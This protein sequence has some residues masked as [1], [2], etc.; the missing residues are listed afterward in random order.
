[1]DK[2]NKVHVTINDHAEEH[3]Y[4]PGGYG[5]T[6]AAAS[7]KTYDGSKDADGLAERAK[8]LGANLRAQGIVRSNSLSPVRRR[9][10]STFRKLHSQTPGQLYLR[11]LSL[12]DYCEEEDD[13][14]SVA[15]EGEH[16]PLRRA[17]SF[18]GTDL[19]APQVA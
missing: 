5:S 18:E 17:L 2:K 14:D 4:S 10:S 7:H 15:G 16:E 12:N 3:L 13:L 19:H 11:A 9:R 6:T 8:E 1:M